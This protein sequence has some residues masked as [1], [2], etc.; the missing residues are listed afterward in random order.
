MAALGTD[1]HFVAKS[2]VMSMPF[3]GTFLRKLGHFSFHR[4][5][6]PSRLHQAEQIES[7]LVPR[8]IGLCFSRRNFHRAVRRA[9]ISSRR[10]QKQRSPRNGKLFPS[11]STERARHCAMAPGFRVPAASPLRFARQSRRQP[12]RKTGRKSCACAMRRAKRLPNSRANPSCKSPPGQLS[13]KN[14]A[15]Q[16][17]CS[18]QQTCPLR[19]EPHGSERPLQKRRRD[20]FC[21]GRPFFGRAVFFL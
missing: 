21:R 13:G 20:R 14:S 5:D 4:D 10:V 17:V 6:P 12:Q 9:P 8:R 11:R 15:S 2:E 18:V 7:A 1:Y 3:F 16:F 19:P